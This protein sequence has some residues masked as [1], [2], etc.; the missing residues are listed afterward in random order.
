MTIDHTFCRDPTPAPT[1]RAIAADHGFGDTSSKTSE[2]HSFRLLTTSSAARSASVPSRSV[3]AS[4]KPAASGLWA[5][6]RGNCNSNTSVS[7]LCTG[8][9]CV[10]SVL[11]SAHRRAISGGKLLVRGALDRDPCRRMASGG[12]AG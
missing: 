10:G 3:S 5:G 9:D 6:S 11:D 8:E 4:R 7:A 2:L 12:G 1:M